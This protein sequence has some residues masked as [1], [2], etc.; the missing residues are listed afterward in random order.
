MLTQK[1]ND[2]IMN[3]MA[4][5]FIIV[6]CFLTKTRYTSPIY[7]DEM[8]Y[9]SN[10]ALMRGLDWSDAVRN[11]PY[12]GYGVSVLYLP[13]FWLF[14]STTLI[15]G[16]VKVL[17]TVLILISYFV[18]QKVLIYIFG[19]ENTIQ[20]RIVAV[21]CCCSSYLLA[22]RNFALTEVPLTAIYF[23]CGFF[24]IKYIET[25][26]ISWKVLLL[27]TAIFML[28][29]HVRTIGSFAVTVFMVLCYEF[30]EL[31]GKER[32]KKWLITIII[33]I[34]GVA[35][36]FGIKS[37][38][39]SSGG[40]GSV[41]TINDISGQAG[42]ISYL[43]SKEGIL[44]FFISVGTKLW[45]F[46]IA[47]FLMPFVG[48]VYAAKSVF[49][50]KN[51]FLMMFYLLAFGAEFAINC[52]YLSYIDRTDMIFYTRYSEYAILPLFCIGLVQI[53]NNQCKPVTIM[54]TFLFEV[55][56]TGTVVYAEK[57]Y[58]C[59]GYLAA[60]I[61]D[62]MLWWEDD[63]INY[64]LAVGLVGIIVIGLYIL[65]DCAQYIVL[66]EFLA[67]WILSC[68]ASYAD[69]EKTLSQDILYGCREVAEYI[70]E[71]EYEKVYVVGDTSWD[72]MH[73]SCWIQFFLPDT[74]VEI[75]DVSN[76]NS[77]K[78]YSGEVMVSSAKIYQDNNLEMNC[79]Y[80][81]ERFFLFEE[82]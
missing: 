68:N 50:N 74:K 58:E 8:G 47:Y 42:K 64:K 80:E 5:T 45:S 37:I 40:A 65:I 32:I 79:V 17:N 76:V 27:I 9:L 15:Y 20:C 46:G 29:I 36:C 31:E 71:Y 19:E 28:M 39:V 43:L 75:V 30:K 6:V 67:I 24:F 81:T 72:G 35:L 25:K 33:A 77:C 22:A 82:N 53:L 18:I 60:C 4:V 1:K 44:N 49:E 70:K 12:Y 38:F 10:A 69:Y 11:L 59:Y 63:Y 61:P 13:F 56:L 55:A 16:G 62:M 51:R 57:A 2:I 3:L 78:V 66:A 21:A 7:A 26:K 41:S 14:S 34:I 23:V 52:A 73:N 48:I 54:G